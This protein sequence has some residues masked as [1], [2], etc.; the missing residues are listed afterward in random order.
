METLIRHI[1]H[2]AT[3]HQ[4]NSQRGRWLGIDATK[5][6]G[7]S[8]ILIKVLAELEERTNVYAYV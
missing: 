3:W 6:T 7:K 1:Q 4:T 8:P 2:L 5:S